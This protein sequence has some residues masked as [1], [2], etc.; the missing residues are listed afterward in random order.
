MKKEEKNPHPYPSGVALRASLS[1]KGGKLDGV[2]GD[3]PFSPGEKEIFL[4]IIY[5][6]L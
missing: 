4:K 6:L 2:G 1:R 5:C 3:F